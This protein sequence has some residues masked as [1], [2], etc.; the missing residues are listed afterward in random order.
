MDTLVAKIAEQL[1]PYFSALSQRDLEDAIHNALA[2]HTVTLANQSLTIN[3]IRETAMESANVAV[4]NTVTG[5]IIQLAVTV[6]T[7]KPK[8][9]AP[10]LP[11]LVIGRDADITALKQRFG[12]LEGH[13]A[14]TTHVLTTIRGWPGVGKT[15][16]AAVFA[17]DP[18]VIQAY[19]DGILWA[20]LGQNPSIFAELHAW[21]RA[22]GQ[23]LDAHTID[24]ASA[25]LRGIL[26]D[27]RCL[28]IVDD[29]WKVEHAQP[30]QVGGSQ[31]AILLTSRL[32]DVAYH[33]AP[34]GVYELRVLTVEQAM[35]LLR[36][37]APT[38]V[39][40]NQSACYDLVT[41]LE[42]LPLALCVAGRLLRKEQAYGLHV[43]RLV[44]ELREGARLI[45]AQA[46][47]DRADLALGTTPTIAALLE[48]S[49]AL[50]DERELECFAYLGVFAPKPATFDQAAMASV[51]QLDDP[52]PIIR[53]FL[54]RG[55]LE[56]IQLPTDHDE[57]RYWMHAV[58][59]AHAQSFLTE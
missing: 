2:G 15:T 6:P 19:P 45:A 13:A 31:C 30:F 17:H 53:S 10:P 46:P 8:G 59:V 27:K 47:A 20:S 22:L 1:L 32:P 5:N 7:P 33:I 26:R 48:K 52:I 56:L 11:H 41:D 50:L 3:V 43:E 16:L 29:V 38:V 42:G 39:A 55:L 34:E 40:Q 49:T 35:E 14:S 24:E 25:Q 9:N 4:G 12:V 21:G 51:W 57:A 37:L 44:A 54:D 28:L 18:T 58:L 23:P 36:E